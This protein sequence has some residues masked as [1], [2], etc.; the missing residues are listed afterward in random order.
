MNSF[1]FEAKPCAPQS[2]EEIRSM[3]VDQDKDQDDGSST[4]SSEEE[5]EDEMETSSL[6]ALEETMPMS[7]N[8]NGRT[9]DDEY[10]GA[11]GGVALLS[12]EEEPLPPAKVV[13]VDLASVHRAFERLFSIV[14]V[15]FQGALIN[16]ITTLARTLETDLHSYNNFLRQ[17][18]YINIYLIVMEIPH[19][20]RLEYLERAT[21]QFCKTL[22]QLS[23]DVQAQLARVWAKYSADKLREMVQRLQQLI[24]VSES[25]TTI[26]N[27]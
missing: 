18:N 17:P 24:T 26:N 21:P 8:L 27:Y 5:E 20:D 9:L 15:P 10:T 13:T 1:L 22:G 7:D 19:L 2:K 12:D 3:E 4:S 11:V 23:V 14:D 6:S 25:S 16:A